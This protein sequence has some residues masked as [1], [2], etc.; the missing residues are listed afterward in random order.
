DFLTDGI[1]RQDEFIGQ[2]DSF[3]F[4]ALNGKRI[5]VRGCQST[6]IPP[7]AYMYLTGKLVPHAKAILFGNEHDN[8]VVFKHEQ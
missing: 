4:S 1:F 5:L 8:V 2:V 6:V 3:D 7:W